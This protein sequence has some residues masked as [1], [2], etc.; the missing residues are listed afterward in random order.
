MKDFAIEHVHGVEEVLL[1]LDG[2]GYFDV[3]DR[4]DKWVRIAT[5]KGDMIMLPP[6]IYHRFELDSNKYIKVQPLFAGDPVRIQYNR[7]EADDNEHR[8]AY[9][10]KF[11]DR[12]G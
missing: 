5:T 3:R 2:S 9:V 8:R 12:S 7:P 1:V 10:R 4:N 6:G 11:L